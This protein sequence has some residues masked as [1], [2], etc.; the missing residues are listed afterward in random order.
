MDNE[1]ELQRQRAVQRFLA[2][3]KPESIYVSLGRTKAWLCKWVDRY[4][5]D[6]KS[7]DETLP[8]RPFTNQK[9]TASEVEEIVKLVRLKLYNNLLFC[10]AQA[11]LWELEELGIRPLPSMRTINRI[12]CRNEL[13][14]RRTGRYV[15]KGK[16]Y[17]KLP[18]LLPNQSHQADHVGPCYLKGTLRFY[19]LNV[20]D[21]AS[22]RCGLDPF[23]A[24]VRA[25]RYS[26]YMGHLETLGDAR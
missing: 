23:S 2:G 20:V 8:R 14:H 5:E 13:T 16:I 10:G 12:L 1:V 22:G 18:S 3:E 24:Q 6:N 17:P 25:V 26:R 19:S 11:I 21:L 9:R 7:W 4:K 15:P